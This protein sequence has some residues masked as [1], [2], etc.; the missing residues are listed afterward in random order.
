MFNIFSPSVTEENGLITISHIPTKVLQ[1]DILRIF[2]TSRVNKYMFVSVTRGSLSFYSFF[3]LEVYNIVQELLYN[4]KSWTNVRSL[5]Q[6]CKALKHGTWLQNIDNHYE[7][8]LDLTRLTNLTLDPLDFQEKLLKTYNETLSAY[9][10]KGLLI[11][12]TAG[13]GKTFMGLAISECLKAERVVIVCPKNALYEVWEKS[14]KKLLKTDK[15]YWICADAKRYTGER[16][17]IFHYETLEKAF[18]Y[19]PEMLGRKTC[20]ILDESHNLNELKSLRTIRFIDF[21]K[22]TRSRDV[23]RLSGTPIKATAIETIPLFRSIDPLFTPE[24][25]EAFRKIFQGEANKATTILSKRLGIVTYVVEKKQLNLDEPIFL[26]LKI[27]V[28]DGK[29]FTLDQ[30]GKDMKEFCDERLAFYYKNM[31]NYEKQYAALVSEA[32]DRLTTA[33]YSASEIAKHKQEFE[34]YKK[35]IILIRDTFKKNRFAMGQLKQDMAF[36]NNFEKTVIIPELGT[37]DKKEQFKFVK[38]LIKYPEYKVQGECLGQVVG[39][40]RI[41]AAVAMVPYIDYEQVLNSTLKKTLIFTSFTEALEKCER[42]LIHMKLR[43]VTVY[44]KNSNQLSSTIEKF[45]KDPEVDPLITTFAS[46][47]T[48]VPLIMAD[49]ILMLN[50]P[51]RDYI[52]QQTVSRVHRLGQTSEV[53]VINA[54]LDTGEEANISSRNVDILKW[55]QQQVEA[56]MQIE[57]PFKIENNEE[58][59]EFTVSEESFSDIGEAMSLVKKEKTYFGFE[60]W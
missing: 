28:P 12:G 39:R 5:E 27:K 59:D 53:R 21:A 9:G 15:S 11:A 1:R 22:A 32:Y 40:R 2:N 3:A 55:S 43:P 42:Y 46:L 48:A 56:I 31:P 35:T 18:A 60:D 29:Y 45:A 51:F 57:V 52:L 58:T 41:E 54:Y 36:A 23:L 25:E 16:F 24:V 10:L 13:S 26:D 7:P 30:L 44:G 47:S 17:L 8:R 49:T 34:T 20:V 6:I 38:T 37:R 33:P 4:P 19:L 14:I 50:A